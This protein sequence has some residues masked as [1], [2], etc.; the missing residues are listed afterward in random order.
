MVSAPYAHMQV[1]AATQFLPLPLL[2]LLPDKLACKDAAEGSS[3]E[4]GAA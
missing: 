4:K 2:F 1:C 3:A